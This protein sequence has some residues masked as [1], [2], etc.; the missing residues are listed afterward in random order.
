M[1]TFIV[2]DLPDKGFIAL[3]AEEMRHVKVLRIQKDERIH[4][5][6]GQ[7]KGRWAT[8][9]PN[10]GQCQIE[11]EFHCPPP[12][13]PIHLA[14]CV[15]RHADRLEWMTEKLA[16]LG[17]STL[18]L[19]VSQR[20]DKFKVRM[21]RLYKIAAESL[22]QSHQNKLLEI[23]EP[24]KLMDWLTQPPPIPMP[25][26][27]AWCNAPEDAKIIAQKGGTMLIGPEGDFT[28]IEI[29]ELKKQQFQ[30]ISFGSRIMRTETAAIVSAVQMG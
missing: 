2:P 12:L 19:L 14:V 24:R 6:D 29:E 28:D 13:Y 20:M 17:I 23:K 4:L 25:K 7:G 26:M 27:V 16:E 9:E 15:P 3:P 1:H 21:E 30:I 5:T 11:S 10:S 8:F 22:K 18:H